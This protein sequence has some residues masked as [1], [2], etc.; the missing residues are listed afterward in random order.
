MR[1]YH[2]KFTAWL[3]L[4]GMILIAVL[5][6]RALSKDW[7]ETSFLALL[8]TSEQNPE[9]AAIVQQRDQ[10]LNRKLIWL[11]GAGD[12][13]SAIRLAEQLKQTLT[14]SALF[15]N[16]TLQ[17]PQQKYIDQ[18]QQLFPLRYQLLTNETVA[19]LNIDPKQFIQQN[20]QMLYSPIGQL[21]AANLEH[22]PLLLFSR[23]FNAAHPLKFNVEQGV[24]M[25]QDAG[26]YWALLLSD[27]E[28][29][30]LQLDKLEYLQTL[31]EN[32]KAHIQELHGELLVTG[33]PLFTAH[34]SQSAKQEI[35]I[36]GF[37]SSA[38]IILLLLVTF[39][40][41]RPLLLSFLAIGSGMF[42]ALV[43]TILF[44]GKI[45]IL[46]LVFGASLIG[47]ADDYAQHY[48]CDSY[49]VKNWNA[50]KGL[51][52][53][54][55]GL[56]IG[57]LSN[58]LSYAGLGLSPFLGLQQMALF[59]AIGL[60][61]AWLTVVL[62]F[63][64]LLTG[65]SFEH[66]PGI[67]KLTRH[68]EHSWPLWLFKNRRKLSLSLIL[69]VTGG[70][71]QLTPQDDVRLLQ[72][73]SPELMAVTEKIRSLLPVSPEQQFFLVSGQDQEAWHQNEQSLTQQ[74][75]ALKAQSALG[76]YEAISDFWP[77]LKQQQANYQLLKDALY[78]SGLTEKYMLNLG[79]AHNAIQTELQVF[80]TAEHQTLDLNTWLEG[81]DESKQQLWLGCE[82]GQCRSIVSLIGIKDLSSVSALAKLPGVTWIDQV[83]QFSQLFKRYRIRASGLLLSAFCLAFLGL[84]LKFGWRNAVIITSV[85]LASLAVTLAALGWSGQLFSLF[86]LFAL[87]L[88]LGIG[89]DYAI[90]FFIAEDRRASTSLGVTI[91]ALTTLLA[92]G[93]LAL[94]STQIVQAFGVT[95][96][97][98]IITA[99]LVSPLI[100]LKHLHQ[101]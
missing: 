77:S 52:F 94:S 35:S 32:A 98:G 45:H 69:F 85:P 34:G 26:R 5:G 8:P 65:F 78:D 9:I 96:G 6:Y 75:N 71:W 7:L 22:D 87:L 10:V 73:V 17:I 39:R 28:N 91:S 43:L 59:S 20:L 13:T 44:F 12:S 92:F 2:P 60:L 30:D 97:C 70:L 82:H 95:V 93:L 27:L 76:H 66:V 15:S 74:L 53:I 19:T 24:V 33:V 63:P 58:L 48:L 101:S 84:S 41:I 3:W 46:T 29:N 100:G 23:Y 38:G 11:I 42:A 83:D 4:V 64:L 86:N 54:L 90:F 88:V 40:S 1:G 62:V 80:K 89:I 81:S 68:W 61:V 72:S 99:L 47:V 37:G 79:F 49:G 31:V 14:Q 56:F 21:Q 36:I 51:R 50:E 16:L 25:V 67:L 18:Y 57:L 55:P